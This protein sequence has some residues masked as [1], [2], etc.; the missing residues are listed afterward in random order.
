[1]GKRTTTSSQGICPSFRLKNPGTKMSARSS[2]CEN[3]VYL[4]TRFVS[5]LVPN[6]YLYCTSKITLNLFIIFLLM[7]VNNII[8]NNTDE[9][10]IP[11]KNTS[12]THSSRFK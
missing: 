8:N 9:Y 12:L 4:D 2:T 6:I 11:I 5:F 1:M 10:L 3:K 7:H